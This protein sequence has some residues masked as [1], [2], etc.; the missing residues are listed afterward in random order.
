MN[1]GTRTRA[2]LADAADVVAAE[3]DEHDVL[4]ALLLVALQLLGETQ[5][6]FV[7]APARRVPAIGCVSTRDPST[8]T[9]ISGDDADDRH[10]A[11]A[12]EIHVGRRIDVAQRAVDRERIR[13]RRRPR[14]A[15]R[16]RPGRCRRRRCVPSPSR[17]CCS[18]RSCVCST[19]S[20]SGLAA[21]GACARGCARARARGTES[22]RT[23]TGRAT[24]DPRRRV[25]R[26]LAMIRMRCCTW[27]KAS[28]V[29]NSMNPASSAPSGTRRDRRAW[30]RT[31][32]PRRS[33]DTRPRR[34]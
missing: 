4:G 12:D 21:S 8:R 9:S 27:S 15:A 33:R 28:T 31:R 32:T 6:L 1:C 19:S 3:V 16:A 17:T 26:A 11:H 22:S 18:K 20:A 14:S 2:V 23:R 29:S 24:R 13:R 7:V 30:V 10:A 34:R 25:M 5:V